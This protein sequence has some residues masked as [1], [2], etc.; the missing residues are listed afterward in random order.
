MTGSAT[1]GDLAMIARDAVAAIDDAQLRVLEAQDHMAPQ[2]A[3]ELVARELDAIVR[4]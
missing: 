1:S 3:P 4:A 2:T